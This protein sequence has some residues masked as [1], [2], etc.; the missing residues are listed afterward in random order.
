MARPTGRGRLTCEDCFSIDV[1]EWSRRGLLRDGW[2]FP[3]FGNRGS[4]SVYIKADSVV[5]S[6][7]WQNPGEIASRSIEQRVPIAHTVCHLG[8]RRAWFCCTA[9]SGG[10]FCLRRVAVLYS[11][12][13]SFACRRCH[14]LAYASQQESPRFRRISRARKIR[15][16][17][18]GSPNLFDNFPAKPPRMHWRTYD[19]LRARGETADATAF[20][21]F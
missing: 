3:W 17:L 5:L 21:Y 13:G 12:G 10:K 4:M 2:E 9:R 20:A 19:R 18:G 15:T 1:R 16:S 11:F 6:F 8:G 7:N 14:G